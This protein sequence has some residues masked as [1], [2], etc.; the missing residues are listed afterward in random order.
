MYAYTRMYIC[1]NI[2]QNIYIL[3]LQF[4]L[5]HFTSIFVNSLRHYPYSPKRTLKRHSHFNM[6]LFCDLITLSSYIQ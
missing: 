6:V 4:R 5:S 1:V 3:L 2:I